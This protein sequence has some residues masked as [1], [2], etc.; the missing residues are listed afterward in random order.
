[1]INAWFR[2]ITYLS[3]YQIYRLAW[4]VSLIWLE[5]CEEYST[6]SGIHSMYNN[7]AQHTNS[8]CRHP[9]PLHQILLYMPSVKLLEL[10]K[11]D[12]KNISTWNNGKC[13]KRHD[14]LIAIFQWT[15]RLRM[16]DKYL[17]WWN[18]PLPV[19]LRIKM[20]RTDVHTSIAEVG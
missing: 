9:Y 6:E 18:T 15:R 20:L 1:M 8:G 5:L 12:V 3:M 11:D 17:S 4:I 16:P 10:F 13:W 7:Y 14:K 19:G 2:F